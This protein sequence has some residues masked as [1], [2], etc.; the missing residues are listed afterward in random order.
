MTQLLHRLSPTTRSALMQNASCLSTTA[1]SIDAI[2]EITDQW[3]GTI[4]PRDVAGLDRWW[5][6]ASF[7]VAGKRI[8]PLLIRGPELAEVFGKLAEPK[9]VGALIRA[10]HKNAGARPLSKRTAIA[11]AQEG[12]VR[13]FLTKQ[14][15]PTAGN[16]KEGDPYA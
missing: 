9:K 15:K 7:T 14:A 8:G 16:A 2:A 13:E 3:P 10:A 1:G 6:Y 12:K 5:H 11:L 4:T